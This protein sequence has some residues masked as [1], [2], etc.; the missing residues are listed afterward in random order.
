VGIEGV[1]LKYHG[2]VPVLGRNVVDDAVANGDNPLGD[3]L[4]SG[5]HAQ[6]GGLATARG[7]DEDQELLVLDE[8][9]E[10]LHG[11]YLAKSLPNMF[12]GNA[13]HYAYI[14]LWVYIETMETELFGHATGYRLGMGLIAKTVPQRL[15]DR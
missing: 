1:A 10:V 8:N 3:F 13:G 7:A 5:L 9:V 15:W 4:Q 14:S 6:A 2:D 12:I 11:D